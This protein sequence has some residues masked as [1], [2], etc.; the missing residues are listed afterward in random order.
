MSAMALMFRKVPGFHRPLSPDLRKLGITSAIRASGLNSAGGGVV[1]GEGAARCD[2]DAI[3]RAAARGISLASPRVRRE[4][5]S[6]P[7]SR[8]THV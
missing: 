6:G 1:V 8:S 7:F 4:V 3:C 5:R 2:T